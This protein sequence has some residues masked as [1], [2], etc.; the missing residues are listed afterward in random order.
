MDTATVLC[1]LALCA[2]LAQGI[3]LKLELKPEFKPELR[4]ELQP[5]RAG[6]YSGPSHDAVLKTTTLS[7]QALQYFQR[8]ENASSKK[9]LLLMSLKS[10]EVVSIGG[11]FMPSEEFLSSG[12]EQRLEQGQG[13][14]MP[15]RGV[16][17]LGNSNYA[18]HQNG[19]QPYMVFPTGGLEYS[20]EAGGNTQSFSSNRQDVKM[21]CQVLHN[22][23]N[24][25]FLDT[26]GGDGEFHSN[27]LL[28]EIFGWRGIIAEPNIYTYAALWTKMRKAWLFLGCLSPHENGTKV[29]WGLDENIDE[30]SGHQIHAFPVPD[31]LTEMGG[32]KTVDFWNVHSGNYEAEILGETLLR[33]GSYIEFGVIMVTFGERTT[34]LGSSAWVQARSRT[35]TESVIFEIMQSA[36]FTFIGNGECTLVD[37][38]QVGGEA[39]PRWEC[40]SHVFVNPE[41]FTSR[42]LYVPT[43]MR[44]APP[45]QTSSLQQGPTWQAFWDDWDEGMSH[46][47]EVDCTMAYSAR[48]RADAAPTEQVP[49]AHRGPS[50]WTGPLH[51]GGHYNP[52][53]DYN[54]TRVPQMR[55]TTD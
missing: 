13:Q 8:I 25:F 23:T 53:P 52:L 18:V 43:L 24:G 16:T 38:P 36:G 41:Y 7:D 46:D 39:T 12:A 42:N 35:D 48:S 10:K 28:L 11:D 34:G 20:F 17:N 22:V 40:N 4:P 55:E 50:Q 49:Y 54:P 26:N 33:S 45:V 30:N 32:L 6:T 5:Q 2:P 44:P 19:G 47:Q 1:L 37:D 15:P 29:G 14:R 3:G 51:E 21:I 27:T 31:F 9:P